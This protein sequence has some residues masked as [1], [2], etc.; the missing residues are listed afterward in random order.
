MVGVGVESCK[1]RFLGC[2][3]FYLLVRTLLLQDV[4]FSHSKLRHRQREGCQIGRGRRHH[5]ASMPMADHTAW[6]RLAKTDQNS[7]CKLI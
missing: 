1:N 6:L 2:G 4:S 7:Q 5:D 3:I